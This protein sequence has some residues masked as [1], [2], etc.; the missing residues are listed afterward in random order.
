MIP[1]LLLLALL[2]QEPQPA[3]K[4][5][6]LKGTVVNALTGELLSKAIVTLQGSPA[7][8][9]AMTDAEGKFGI[10]GTGPAEFEVFAS[11][12]GFIGF[13]DGAKLTMA[14]GVKKD[15]AIKMTPQCVLAGHVL[16][17]DGDPVDTGGV[18]VT[19]IVAGHEISSETTAVDA[20][21]YFLMA[22]L[23]AGRYIVAASLVRIFFFAPALPHTGLDYVRTYYPNSLTAANSIPVVL[24][25][26]AQNR[27][28]EIRLRRERVF[29]VRGRVTNLPKNYLGLS[30]TSSATGYQADSPFSQIDSDGKFEFK[31]VLPGDYVIQLA[32]FPGATMF[33]RIPITVS[34]DIE[35]LTVDL[36]PGTTISGS[37]KMEGSAAPPAHWPIVHFAGTDSSPNSSIKE[38]GTFEWSNVPPDTYKT[39]L[40]PGESVYLK[41]LRYNGQPASMTA[42][43][44]TTRGD[45]TLEIILSPN[46]AEISGVVRDQDGA[47]IGAK[48]VTIWRMGEEPRSTLSNADGSFQFGGLAPGEYRLLAWEEIEETRA[49]VPEFVRQFKA[50]EVTLEEGSHGGIDLKLIPKSA[51]DEGVAKLP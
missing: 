23:P 13:R 27:S 8:Q 17:E 43:D 28:L 3:D 14:E 26:G 12:Q 40:T 4:K 51:I 42:W 37:L 48:L 24:T 45:G 49:V 19:R 5:W 10:E 9:S 11:R 50:S 7:S 18:I 32:Q 39:W 29:R 35:G 30:L 16:D 46:V 15:L 33:C 21:G 47:P 25:A 20:D 34:H 2:A 36:A 6:T 1:A 41:S 31:G 22:T 44:L 38:D